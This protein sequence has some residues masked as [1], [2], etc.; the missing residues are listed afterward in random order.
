MRWTSS[1]STSGP[2]RSSCRSNPRTPS[3]CPTSP[4]RHRGGDLVALASSRPGRKSPTHATTGAVPLPRSTVSALLTNG[5]SATNV[6][7]T[8]RACDIVTWHD[9]P[10]PKHALPQRSNADVA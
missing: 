10:E 3:R 6:A 7:V 9:G 1:R 5:M 4:E 2:Y 8:L